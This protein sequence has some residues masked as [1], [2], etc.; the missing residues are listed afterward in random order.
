MKEKREKVKLYQMSKQQLEDL[1]N[2][3]RGLL[4]N[5]SL[6]SNLP[7]KVSFIN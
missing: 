5:K 3:Q 1:L 2:K 4:K 6:I 7:D